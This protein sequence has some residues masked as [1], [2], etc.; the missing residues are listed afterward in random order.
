[1]EGTYNTTGYS[2]F[3]QGFYTYSGASAYK[4]A[5]RAVLVEDRQ[6]FSFCNAYFYSVCLHRFK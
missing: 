1:M 4:R 2:F 6:V 5:V 3:D